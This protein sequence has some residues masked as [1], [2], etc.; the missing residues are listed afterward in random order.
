MSP[1]VSLAPS[2][3]ET[4]LQWLEENHPEYLSRSRRN[5]QAIRL[6]DSL[7]RA[8]YMLEEAKGNRAEQSRLIDVLV[9][10]TPWGQ[11]LHNDLR[12]WFA[13]GGYK[14]P[15]HIPKAAALPS[16][17]VLSAENEEI[18]DMLMPDDE[19]ALAELEPR[20]QSPQ[21]L[22]DAVAAEELHNDERYGAW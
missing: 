3:V 12:A 17:A 13:K 22:E 14:V 16:I 9:L 2:W 1:A 18:I 20:S 10:G 5:T 6:V 4:T 15:A 11:T 7:K 21:K 19:K 8:S